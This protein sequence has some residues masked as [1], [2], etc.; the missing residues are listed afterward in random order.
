MFEV[1]NQPPPLEPY[2]VFASDIVL[3][4]AVKR[5]NASWANAE[6]DAV[7]VGV[8]QIT[9]IADDRTGIAR[10]HEKNTRLPALQR[11]LVDRRAILEIEAEMRERP[12][13]RL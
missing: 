12:D 5:E 1:R 6:L 2:N 4:E 10:S 8:A 11:G 13:R 9:V 7:S 3:R